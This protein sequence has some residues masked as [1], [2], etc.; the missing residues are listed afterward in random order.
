[1]QTNLNIFLLKLLASEKELATKDAEATALL[2]SHIGKLEQSLVGLGDKV[3]SLAIK[4]EDAL[5]KAMEAG[6]LKGL[7]SN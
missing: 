5:D 7:N 2:A 3:K 4:N 6:R 1:M